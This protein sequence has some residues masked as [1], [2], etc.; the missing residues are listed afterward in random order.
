M[1]RVIQVAVAGCGVVGGALLELV[2][3]HEETLQRRHGVRFEVRR[4]LVRDAA[5]PRGVAVDRAVFTERVDH[6]L[7]TPVDVVVEAIG[8]TTTARSV[9][10]GALVRGR[11][12]VT[13]NKALLRVE[14]PIL[15]ALARAHRAQGAALDFEAAVGGSVP[16]VRLLRDSLAG[17]GLHRIRGVLNGTT[18]YILSRVEQGLPFADAL[19]AAQRAGFAEADP[20][21]DL[22]GTDAADKIAVLAWL[23]FGADPSTLEIRHRGIDDAVAAEARAVAKRGRA[24]RLVATAVRIGDGVHASV[25]PRVVPRGHPFAQV[26]D[27]Q[28]LIQ[29]ESESAGTLTVA[30]AG[31][32]G[33]ATASAILAD[34]LRHGVPDAAS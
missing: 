26:R 4:V 6:F 27:E 14:G 12:L 28:N 3:R 5:R 25:A 22:D 18:N 29:L 15:A 30:G 8:G 17:Q 13:A 10:H 23:G 19:A 33:S 11:R 31:A 34:L 21:R 16:V 20:T 24:I 1:T 2:A 7:E 9:A 32:G